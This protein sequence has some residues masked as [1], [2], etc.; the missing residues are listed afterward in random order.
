MGNERWMSEDGWSKQRI[1]IDKPVARS[2]IVDQNGDPYTKSDYMVV[3]DESFIIR[4]RLDGV[5]DFWNNLDGVSVEMRF[6]EDRWTPE[7]QE[8]AEIELISSRNTV[9]PTF[10]KSNSFG[11]LFFLTPPLKTILPFLSTK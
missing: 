4:S 11:L 5:E 8:W 10:F 3:Q 9:P 1:S 2:Y 6:W 7:C